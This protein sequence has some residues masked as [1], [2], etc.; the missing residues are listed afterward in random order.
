MQA[1]RVEFVLKVASFKGR[2]MKQSENNEMEL[3]LRG[4]ARRHG[5][6]SV[7][8]DLATQDEVTAGHLDA[9]ELSSYAEGAL[10]AL[11]RARY[12][13]HLADCSRCRNIVSQLASSSGAAVQ[14]QTGERERSVGFWQRV[15]A[16]LS[17][18]VLRYAVPALALF[19]VIAVGLVALR[20]QPQGEFVAQTQSPQPELNVAEDKRSTPEGLLKTDS[21]TKAVAEKTREKTRDA[22]V[23]RADKGSKAG[24][25]ADSPAVLPP[26]PYA[27]NAPA[28]AAKAA[29]KDAETGQVTVA[30]Q[31]N[32]AREPVATPATQPQT[33]NANT[34]AGV[35]R[36]QEKPAEREDA[37]EQQD[38]AGERAKSE[39]K[40]NNQA[41]ARSRNTSIGRGA[42]LSTGVD[43]S[44]EAGTR[45]VSGRRFR[46]QGE[47]WV[48]TAYQSSV[49]LITVGRGSEQFRALV[50]DEPG[51][52]VIADQL[53]GEIILVWKGRAYRIR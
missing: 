37:R 35:A 44:S 29:K 12:T 11:T 1:S 39:D 4:L 23:A 48:D 46:R 22:D 19:A 9:D 47:V 13:A 16:F 42:L 33:G 18:Q 50:A 38:R 15:G 8:R 31:P 6:S 40:E 20:R 5:G 36:R 10:P 7:V 27:V 24:E 34:A 32:F 43:K 52:R 30:Q 53:P 21:S 14:P 41:A 49:S 28:P 51:I 17:P 45:T 3:W 25:E 2:L 26:S